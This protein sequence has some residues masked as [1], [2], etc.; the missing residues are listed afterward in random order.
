MHLYIVMPCC[1]QY[2]GYEWQKPSVFYSDNDTNLLGLI[3][4]GVK[5]SVVVVLE[6]EVR[7]KDLHALWKDEC[8]KLSTNNISQRLRYKLIWVKLL[9]L[10]T[11]SHSLELIWRKRSIW[12]LI[13]PSLV[14]TITASK[15]CSLRIQKTWLSLKAHEMV[16]RYTDSFSVVYFFVGWW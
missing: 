3:A 5:S 12:P 16:Q 9:L 6:R 10:W 4:H 15:V 14:K 8:A 2:S 1:L 7:G 13:T 11:L